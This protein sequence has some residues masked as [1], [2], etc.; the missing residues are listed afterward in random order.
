M[1]DIVRQSFAA[2]SVPMEGKL[3]CMYPDHLGKVT[4][5]IGNLIDSPEA[6]WE[7]RNHGA[8]FV[9]KSNPG[10]EAT[11][12]EVF[13]EWDRVKHD[14]ELIGHLQL[15]RARA[16]LILTEQG[17]L[18]LVD[19]KL[20]QFERQLQTHPAFSGL[21]DWPADAQ[22]GLFSMAWAMGP[23]FGPSWPVFSAAV[24]G[25]KPNWFEAV[26]NC[27]MVNDWLIRRN[28]VNRG[29]F[30]NAA[31]AAEEKQ[32]FDQLY[33]VVPGRRPVLRLGNTDADHAGQGYDSDDSVSTLQG[34]LGYLGFYAR[35]ITG[36]L[37][38][39]TDEAVRGFQLFERSLPHN[40]GF[41]VDGVVGQ[42]T[43]A[44]L[45]YVVP[46]N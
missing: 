36:E 17:I 8:P 5:G 28:A 25:P 2:F 43:W 4:V 26:V 46:T 1:F 39:A 44:A 14:P 12:A 30:R 38:D 40:S 23:G 22:L 37:D 24:G 7:T 31:W 45:G 35:D 15:A 27:N 29:L 13:A 19:S 10:V 18:N 33:I 21:D 11:R 16:T 3:E 34:F 20:L 41:A 32:A 6:A 9:H 42:T